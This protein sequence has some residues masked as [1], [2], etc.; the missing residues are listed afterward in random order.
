MLNSSSSA[1]SSFFALLSVRLDHFQD[2][3]DVLL[4]RHPAEDRGLLRQVADAE[5][6]ALVHRQGRDVV[7][8]QFDPPAVRLD[9]AGDHVEHRGLAGAVGAQEPDRL[10]APH[11]KAHTLDDLPVAEALLDPLDRQ[12]ALLD[13][14]LM[15]GLRPMPT[16][17][18]LAVAHLVG[19]L[20]IALG[21]FRLRLVPARAALYVV[22]PRGRRP[23]AII[24]PAVLFVPAWRPLGV[25]VAPILGLL[26]VGELLCVRLVPVMPLSNVSASLRRNG[27]GAASG[28]S[29]WRAGAGALTTRTGAGRRRNQDKM[30]N[31]RPAPRALAS[32]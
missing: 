30:S 6:A 12:I 15:L 13:R 20:G 4:H 25:E 10:A 32:V 27:T 31:R 19:M 14:L 17:R 3:P 21:Q 26:R 2:R 1:S 23:V 7:A 11:V 22:V 18:R 29:R 28:P 9:Q 24:G 16:V 8:V 5:P